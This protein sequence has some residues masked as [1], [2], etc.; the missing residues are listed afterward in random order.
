M[1]AREERNTPFEPPAPLPEN[2]T[3]EQI[4]G[5]FGH[6]RFAVQAAGCTVLEAR[7]GYAICRMPLGSI[8]CNAM[9]A[10]MGGA[11]FTLADFSFAVASNIGGSSTVTADSN[12]RYLSAPKGKELVSTAQAVK[13]G[14]HLVFYQI[15][16]CDELGTKVAQVNT[17]GYRS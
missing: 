15:D 3:L 10:V 8:H 6:D 16:I 13:Q 7:E 11:I 5:F 17:T 1:P 4:N 14:R 2:P 9:G 12:I